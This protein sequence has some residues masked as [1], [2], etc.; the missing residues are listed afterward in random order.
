LLEGPRFL[1]LVNIRANFS[2][3]HTQYWHGINSF[4]L[5]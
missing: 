3:L 2:V 5:R 1:H 4:E